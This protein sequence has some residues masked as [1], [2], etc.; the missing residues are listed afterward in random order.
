MISSL[1][2]IFFNNNENRPDIKHNFTDG[3]KITTEEESQMI[4]YGRFYGDSAA[5]LL[6]VKDYICYIRYRINLL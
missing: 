4:S 6:I 2:I 5:N 1:R 3:Q